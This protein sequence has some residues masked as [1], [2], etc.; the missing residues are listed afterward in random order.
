MDPSSST[1]SYLSLALALPHLEPYTLL[2]ALFLTLARL[3]PLMVITPFFGGK[4]LP[5]P[6]R[7]MF[8]LALVTLF[9]PQNLLTLH[10]NIPFGVPWI[11]LMF[12]EFLIGF[13]LAFLSSIPFFLVQMSGSLIDHAR[14]SSA[15]QVTDPTT[16]SQTGSIGI[17]FNY[18]LLAIFYGLGGPFIFLE[19]V[20]QSY[21]LMPIDQFLNPSVLNA[22][23]PYWQRASTLLGMTFDLC[24]RIASPALIGILLT[25]LFLGIAN[26]LAPQVQ[27]VFLGMSLKSWVGIALGALCSK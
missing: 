15:L 7:M 10:G 8:S 20:A 11:G 3:L 9:L 2:S 27:I 12:K 19:G 14:G 6:V 25:D 26:R 24:V 21:V 16:Q 4:N 18:S 23:A 22:S 1:D 5:A 17:L 13:V